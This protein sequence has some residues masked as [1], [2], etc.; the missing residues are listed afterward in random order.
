MVAR[1]VDLQRV[2]VTA[3][4]AAHVQEVWTRATDGELGQVG[5]R[6]ADGG[7][8]QE[9][10]HHLVKSRQVIVEPGVGVQ[11]LGVNEVRF[12]RGDL[13]SGRKRLNERISGKTLVEASF[14]LLSVLF[15]LVCRRD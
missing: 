14:F 15:L 6:L 3:D 13:C 1:A 9:G 2:P 11:T 8:K 5:H 12:S 10:A 4:R 7:S